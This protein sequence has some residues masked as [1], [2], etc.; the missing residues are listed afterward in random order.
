MTQAILANSDRLGCDYQRAVELL[1]TGQLQ[2]GS[3][4]L[5]SIAQQTSNDQLRS[6]CMFNLG[7]VL[8]K[9]GQLQ[10]AYST[11][12]DLAHKPA[13]QRNKFDNLARLQVKRTFE[14]ADLR[15]RPPD[16]PPRVQLEITNRCNLRCI[17]CTRNQMTRPQGDM[18]FETVRQVADE[19]C[20]EPGTVLCLYFM[21]EPLL[22]K[23]LEEMAAY[24]D[25]V[26]DRSYSPIVFGIQTNGMLLTKERARSL[27]EAG[28]RGFAFSIDGLEGDLERIRP[29]ASYPVVEKNILGLIDMAEAMGIDDLVVDISK[30]CDDPQAD[31]VKRFR[32]RWE[33]KVRSI[34]LLGITKVEGNSYMSADG[35]VKTI[36][37]NSKPKS[38][39]YCGHGQR[40]LVYWN[41]DFG[42]CCGDIDGGIKLGNIHERTI[43]E[44]WN[45]PEINNI[46][47]KILAADYTD[48][49][50]CMKCP[51]SSK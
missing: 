12:Y 45:S 9:L 19:C 40:L 14:K 21:G 18:S 39:I 47:Q 20:M 10:L 49:D 11:W 32:E 43:H 30:L 51:H 37:S 29:G 7:E 1:N 3:H 23:E 35:S 2:A 33:G 27:L 13:E 15:L 34:H 46:R 17:M 41:G 5:A 22:N 50:A 36:T 25:S 6:Q 28:L 4:L 44:A 48:M 42:F 38:P 31:E 16:F 24:L 26:K 8:E